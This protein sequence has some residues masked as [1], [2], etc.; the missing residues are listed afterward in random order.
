M[1]E[2]LK[3][4]H[5]LG[6]LT[7][8]FAKKCMSL[9]EKKI[10]NKKNR[11]IPYSVREEAFSVFCFKLTSNWHKIDPE[12]YPS[13]YVNFMAHNCLMDLLRGFNKT[14]KTSESI[15][16]KNDIEKDIN[17]TLYTPS[18]IDIRTL[19]RRERA[20][21][22]KHIIKIL[23]RGVSKCEIERQTGISRITLVKWHNKYKKIGQK[24]YQQDK[25]EKRKR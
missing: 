21:I 19:D 13:S 9:A 24:F 4:C 8:E 5:E 17:N 12:K 22:K 11:A 15:K 7:E 25:R 18:K 1:K 3:E 20:N 6:Y 10:N 16:N 14:L 2:A 23:K